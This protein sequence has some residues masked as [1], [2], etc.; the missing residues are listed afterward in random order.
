MMFGYGYSS[1]AQILGIPLLDI[2]Y[3]VD[4]VTGR[5]RVAKGIV[6]I[7]QISIGLFSFGGLAMGGLAFGGLAIG[8]IALGGASFGAIL[9]LGGVAAGYSAI[10]GAAVG[11]YAM[12]GA[13]FGT[14][15][16]DATQQS[17]EAFRYFSDT[18]HIP[19]QVV[20]PQPKIVPL[21]K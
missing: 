11:H 5:M 4:P 15:V 17:P 20:L 13:G 2:A 1:K 12:G 6:A 8:A 14:H 10:G 18:L 3:G 21:T 9:A 16:I 7:G 19:P